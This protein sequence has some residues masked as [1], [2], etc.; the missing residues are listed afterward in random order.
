MV[1]T[2]EQEQQK[3][4]LKNKNMKKVK[5]LLSKLLEFT[6]GLNL[7]GIGLIGIA[8]G[9]TLLFGWGS[10]PGAFVGAFVFKNF[11][12]IIDHINKI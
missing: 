11:K 10:I 7:Y 5:D 1:V 6:T 9:L 2:L 8:L 12:S 4:Y 3:K